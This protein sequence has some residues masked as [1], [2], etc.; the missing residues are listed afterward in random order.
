MAVIQIPKTGAATAERQVAVRDVGVGSPSTLGPPSREVMDA[1]EAGVVSRRMLFP[2]DGPPRTVEIWRAPVIKDNAIGAAIWSRLTAL[3]AC[4][5]PAPRPE[6]M[7]RVLVLL[8]HYKSST[9]ADAVEQG[10]ADDWAED[11]AAYPMWAVEE[12]A[13]TWRRTRKFRPQISEMI[14]LCEAATDRLALERGR[15]RSIV[16][17]AA[18]DRNPLAARTDRLAR[19]LLKTVG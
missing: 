7:S 2:D 9:H 17:A 11:L 12:A 1:I 8:A 3:D 6:L 13:R 19:G 4:M 5:A 18:R 14:E 15:L 10:I 16:D